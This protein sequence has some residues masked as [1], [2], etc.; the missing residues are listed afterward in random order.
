MQ[1]ETRAERG[2]L[3]VVAREAERRRPQRLKAVIDGRLALDGIV[4]LQAIE[5][6]GRREERLLLAGDEVIDHPLDAMV[7]GGWR[8]RRGSREEPLWDFERGTHARSVLRAVRVATYYGQWLLLLL[9][10]AMP[11]RRGQ[12]PRRLFPSEGYPPKVDNP[13][14]DYC[15]LFER[16]IC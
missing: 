15:A 6:I 14:N 7:V 13:E 2:P 3:A 16:D 12:C 1:I 9:R 4:A 5:G 8:R 11:K 10:N